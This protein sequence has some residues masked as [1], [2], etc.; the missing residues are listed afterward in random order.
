MSEE[1]NCPKCNKP[2]M[3]ESTGTASGRRYYRCSNR[4]ECGIRWQEKNAAAVSLG[5]LGGMARAA[6]MSP[7]DREASAIKAGLASKAKRIKV[8]GQTT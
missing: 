7:E 3:L 1:I 2:G 4:E 6:K 5:R 8:R